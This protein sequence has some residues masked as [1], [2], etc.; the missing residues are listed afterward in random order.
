MKFQFITVLLLL[1]SMACNNEPEVR[2][3]DM[4]NKPLIEMKFDKAKWRLKEGRHYPYR[5]KML[6]DVVYNDTIRNLSRNEILDL[7]GEPSYYRDDTT[8]LYYVVRQKRLGPWP[9][10]TK[11][12]VV[13][14][15]GTNSVEWIKIYE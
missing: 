1:G 12:M 8:Y 7:L 15:T 13:K 14:T 9:L 6:N 10:H 11:A 5:E 4:D 3:I 2:T